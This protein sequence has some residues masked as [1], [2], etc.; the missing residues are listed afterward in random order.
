MK[1]M[2]TCRDSARLIL[3]REDRALSAAERA[4][5]GLHLWMCRRCPTLERQVVQ[6]RQALQR[7]NPY[8]GA[9]F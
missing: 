8:K 5:L 9:D 6:M 2:T 4:R 1:L 3:A 7:C